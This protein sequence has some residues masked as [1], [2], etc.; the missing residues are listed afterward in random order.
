MLQYFLI[1]NNG[2][3]FICYS[4]FG[5][6][7]LNNLWVLGDYF[8]SRFY[9]VY[10]MGQNRVGFATSTAYNYAPYI[11]PQTFQNAASTLTPSI[12]NLYNR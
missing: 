10:D 6:S 9:S 11:D 12:I 8:L 2:Q 7:P 3:D 1:L 5:V 4:V